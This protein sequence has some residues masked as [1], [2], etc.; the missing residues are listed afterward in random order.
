MPANTSV[1]AQSLVK[2]HLK[3]ELQLRRGSGASPSTNVREAK[4][5][6]REASVQ[7]RQRGLDVTQRL[8]QAVQ[9]AAGDAS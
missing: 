7:E 6:K 1:E 8:Q 2:K 3:Q 9:G 4:R 5:V